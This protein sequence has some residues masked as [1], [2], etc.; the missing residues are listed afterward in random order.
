MEV[1][2]VEVMGPDRIEDGEQVSC[3]AQSFFGF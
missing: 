3:R 1:D 2:P